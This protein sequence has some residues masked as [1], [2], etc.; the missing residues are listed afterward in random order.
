MQYMYMYMYIN[1]NTYSGKGNCR[2]YQTIATLVESTQLY[3]CSA[4]QGTPN[5]IYIKA[6]HT[7]IFHSSAENRAPS[8]RCMPT[9]MKPWTHLPFCNLYLSESSHLH[10]K[11]LEV[12]T[13]NTLE[14]FIRKCR[15]QQ[16]FPSNSPG[17]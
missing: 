12:F 5:D 2:D 8:R 10:Q 4:R 9:N 6:C 11:T 13:T 3:T 14:F 7:K 15:I 1:I 16:D 17:I